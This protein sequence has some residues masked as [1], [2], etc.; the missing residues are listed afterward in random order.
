M[1]KN[2]ILLLLTLMFSCSINYNSTEYTQVPQAKALDLF[3]KKEFSK[4]EGFIDYLIKNKVKSEDGVW[5]LERVYDTFGVELKHNKKFYSILKEWAEQSKHHS[6]DI[7]FALDSIHKA[8][9]YRGSSWASTVSKN[10]WVKWKEYIVLA[11]ENLVEAYKKQPND[12]SIYSTVFITLLGK[13][14]I[15]SQK[16]KHLENVDD[17]VKFYFDKANKIDPYHRAFVRQYSWYLTPR[18]HGSD[19]VFLEFLSSIEDNPTAGIK[20]SALYQIYSY[21]FT[22]SSVNKKSFK[23]KVVFLNEFKK[24]VSNH[25][26]YFYLVQLYFI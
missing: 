22:L 5:F 1:K 14:Y 6:I 26:P 7:L 25:L 18:W 8:W 20:Y 19:K 13:R 16:Y 17:I 15:L 23:E 9:L 10:G 21:S 3:R 4:L 11:Y 2:I 24:Q 12:P